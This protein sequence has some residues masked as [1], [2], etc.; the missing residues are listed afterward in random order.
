MQC[1]LCEHTS[2]NQFFRKEDPHFGWRVYF[3]CPVCR[4]IFLDPANHLDR[5]SEKARY[6]THQNSPDDQRYVQFL[7][8]LTNNLLPEL[9][10]GDRGLDFGCGPGPAIAAILNQE[11]MQVINYDPY[12]FSDQNIYEHK[13]DFITC[14]EV[15]EHFHDPKEEFSNL[16]K[17]IKSPNGVLGF[18]TQMIDRTENFHKWWY[19]RDP[20]H[21]C[22]YN[23]ETFHW[24]ADFLGWSLEFPENSIII[25]KT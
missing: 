9:K 25:F 2:A 7:S 4:L 20:T 8:R 15:I 19:H 16:S 22:F 18:M 17:L 14:T 13:F 10:K 23:E 24:L 3:H 11:G 12:Y 5:S 6:D 1:L 21:V